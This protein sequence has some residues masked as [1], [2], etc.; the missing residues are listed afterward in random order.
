MSDG[1]QMLLFCN[2]SLLKTV[3]VHI[4]LLVYSMHLNGAAT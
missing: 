4:I 1:N 3:S 2:I